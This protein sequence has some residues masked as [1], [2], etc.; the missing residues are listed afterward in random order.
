MKAIELVSFG[1]PARACVCAE[2]DDVG[3]PGPGEVVIA[4]EA[5]AINPADLLIIEGKY[6]T[7]PALPARLGIEGAGR[8]LAVGEGVQGLAEGD[9]V[10]SLGRSNWAERV[11]L[12]ASM[13]IPMPRNADM[14][15]LGMMKANPATAYL[16]LRDYVE[17]APGD[18]I[19][20]NAANSG[21][22]RYLIRL[23]ARRGVKTV[24]LVR[25]QN[26]IDELK[27]LGANVVLVDGDDI[28][29]RVAEATD[30][31]EIRLA[32]DA[33]A[34]A[35]TARLADCLA[36]G[37]VVVNYGLLS[38]QPCMLRPEHTVFRGITLT[39]FW[40]AKLM[41]SMSPDEMRAMYGEL[42]ALVAE[43][44]LHVPVEATYELD[45]IAAALDHASREARDG[46]VVLTPNGPLG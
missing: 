21:V 28:A 42:S 26:L 13:A 40:L 41:G 39:G 29:E 45:A 27:A 37:G 1:Q 8:V 11:R 19:I 33:I 34:G 32:I 43:G 20:Q 25:R 6:A 36:E 16:M 7:R 18:W 5:A 22:G 17:L 46:K 2:V 30:G 38:G 12:K 10:M 15:Q 4:I 9:P 24:N 23:A 31:A 44:V 14:L 3:A 35:A